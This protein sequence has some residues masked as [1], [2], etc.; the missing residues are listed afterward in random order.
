MN[1]SNE[2]WQVNSGLEQYKLDGFR[3]HGE[4][5]FGTRLLIQGLGCE[6]KII[7]K[8]VINEFSK[9]NLQ[10]ELIAFD[11]R[12]IGKSEGE[13]LSFEQVIQDTVQVV[14]AEKKPV[15]LIGHSLGG[16][17]ALRVAELVGELV[18]SVVLICSNPRYNDK[19]KS[20][21][22]WRADQIQ[23]MKT[24]GCIFEKVIPRSFSKSFIEDSSN[25]VAD[26][27]KMLER[28]SSDNYSKLSRIAAE[29]DA[30]DA[31]DTIKTP[32]MMVI[33]TDD[34]NIT[35]KSTSEFALR[36]E[37]NVEIVQGAGHNIPLENPQALTQLIQQFDY[38]NADK[39]YY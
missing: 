13:P 24:V 33:G 37:C 7:W 26:F 1:I 25:K 34:P 20:G 6:S 10:R 18:D 23:S 29:A 27:M 2:Y 5:N 30:L 28:Q 39:I 9:L 36:R 21:F 35:I 11:V 19:N 3:Y 14:C 38:K 4:G 15:Q 17:V 16:I 12:G 22:I 31:F 8:E 32:L